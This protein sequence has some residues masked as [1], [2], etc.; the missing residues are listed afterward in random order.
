LQL[1]EEYAGKYLLNISTKIWQQS[2]FLDM[3]EK[4]LDMAKSLHL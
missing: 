4:R 2:S 3:L 1:S